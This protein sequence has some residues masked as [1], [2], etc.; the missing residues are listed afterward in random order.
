MPSLSG[1]QRAWPNARPIKNPS[2]HRPEGF[3]P[4][5]TRDY[6]VGFSTAGHTTTTTGLLFGLVM[7]ACILGL[8]SLFFC[9]G[10]TAKG[11]LCIIQRQDTLSKFIL[12]KVFP[13]TVAK[14]FRR[15]CLAGRRR[16]WIPPPPSSPAPPRVRAFLAREQP[17]GSRNYSQEVCSNEDY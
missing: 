8:A 3:Y 9:P 4:Q 17:P 1:F 5:A 2:G 10:I 7:A 15:T 14:S 16:R 6:M 11:Y 12:K 13:S